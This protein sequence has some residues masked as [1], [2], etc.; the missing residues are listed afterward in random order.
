MIQSHSYETRNV[1]Q[2]LIRL[3]AP[4]AELLFPRGKVLNT[5]VLAV[6]SA[7]LVTIYNTRMWITEFWDRRQSPVRCTQTRQTGVGSEPI[8]NN[9]PFNLQHRADGHEDERELREPPD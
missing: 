9:V 7:L 5:P 8:L 3:L 4:L 2:R 1:Y 6:R